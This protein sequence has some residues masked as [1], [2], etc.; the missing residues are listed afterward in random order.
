M[1]ASGTFTHY[2]ESVD[3]IGYG[4]SGP[5]HRGSQTWRSVIRWNLSDA[6]VL[7]L[8]Y[9]SGSGSGSWYPC[10]SRPPASS[11]QLRMD[12]Q[13]NYGSGWTT[14]YS[15]GVN[16][17]QCGVGPRQPVSAVMPGLTNSFPATTLTAPC[18]IRVLYYTTLAPCPDRGYPNAYPSAA[19]SEASQS[20][21]VDA[22]SPIPVIV[23]YRPG[24][25]K[26]SG[27]WY[28]HNRGNGWAER[29]SGGWYEMRTEQ[30]GSGSG[31]PPER[32][33]NGSWKNQSKLGAS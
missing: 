28:S 19:Y 16:I 23:D 13:L 6:N 32:K 8:N 15:N 29:K 1:A 26:I 20:A 7:T 4:C 3:Y 24:E 10:S 2:V 27:T 5:F 33:I 18:D 25:R 22:K 12:V 14:I 17:N 31:R 9:V 30:G 11:Y 21:H